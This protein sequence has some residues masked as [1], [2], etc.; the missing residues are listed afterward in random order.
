MSNDIEKLREV[1]ERA[2]PGPWHR[3]I[4]P[5]SHYPTIFA[6][7]NTHVLHL[8]A[9]NKDVEANAE[10]V[11]TFNPATV[12]ALLAELA[13]LRKENEGLRDELHDANDAYASV[14]RELHSYKGSSNDY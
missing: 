2:T 10:F 9:T 14:L 5:A 4:P 7:R 3:N 1:A 8:T 12:L 11:A 6:G 13:A